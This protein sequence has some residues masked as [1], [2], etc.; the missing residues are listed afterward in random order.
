MGCGASGRRHD[1]ANA[2]KLFKA[3]TS[4]SK[5]DLLRRNNNFVAQRD[6]TDC[7]IRRPHSIESR[8]EERPTSPPYALMFLALGHR[9]RRH[10]CYER[11][12]VWRNV[13]QSVP[14]TDRN[15]IAIWPPSSRTELRDPREVLP[16]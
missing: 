16:T 6:T 9:G 10:R 11:V 5:T 2:R 4:E 12:A 15:P 1:S 7:T 8:Q 13:P 14:P 3:S